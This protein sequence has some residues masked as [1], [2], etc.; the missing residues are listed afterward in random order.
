MLHVNDNFIYYNS[1]I[2]FLVIN[3]YFFIRENGDLDVGAIF[4]FSGI[5]N[6]WEY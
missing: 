3:Y 1:L 4:T 2:L 6:F 5:N